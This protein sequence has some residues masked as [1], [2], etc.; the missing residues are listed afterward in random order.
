MTTLQITD[1]ELECALFCDFSLF[2]FLGFFALWWALGVNC[3]VPHAFRIVLFG[4]ELR[5]FVCGLLTND[6]IAEG[7]RLLIWVRHIILKLGNGLTI[8]LWNLHE[9]IAYLSV[10]EA[11]TLG[12]SIIIIF[13]R[14]LR[15]M[16]AKSCTICLWNSIIWYLAPFPW[17]WRI[18]FRIQSRLYTNLVVWIHIDLGLAH[19]RFLSG[20]FVLFEVYVVNVSVEMVNPENIWEGLRV[21]P[22]NELN[23]AL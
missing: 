16:Q 17:F 1:V 11:I 13:F 9:S 10:R 12:C 20:K 5:R 4:W 3:G 21:E 22:W 14:Y 23:V 2:G 18:Q 6:Y 8:L 19:Q 7:T 15:E